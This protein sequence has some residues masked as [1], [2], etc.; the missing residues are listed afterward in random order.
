MRPAPAAILGYVGE[1]N[2][3]NKRGERRLEVDTPSH[4]RHGPECHLA[5][6]R[7]VLPLILGRLRDTRRA[8]VLI[9][10]CSDQPYSMVLD[11]HRS[12]G[13]PHAQWRA[14]ATCPK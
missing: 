10:H 2:K 7:A 6:I 9:L 3:G 13:A 1:N 12:H 4:G 8:L 14:Q 11:D 5:A